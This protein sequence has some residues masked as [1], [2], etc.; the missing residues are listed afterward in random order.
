MRKRKKW[1]LTAAAPAVG[2]VTSGLGT[3]TPGRWQQGAT[4]APVHSL[5][6]M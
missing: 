5:G 4:V 6:A 3:V 1:P 2:P